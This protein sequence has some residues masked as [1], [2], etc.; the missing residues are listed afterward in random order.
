[1][2]NKNA[3]VIWSIFGINSYDAIISNSV[4]LFAY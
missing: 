2:E 4:V 1:M 3:S